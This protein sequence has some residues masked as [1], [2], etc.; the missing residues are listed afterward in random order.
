[1]TKLFTTKLAKLSAKIL[2]LSA[3]LL[4]FSSTKVLAYSEIYPSGFAGPMTGGQA[5]CLNDTPNQL[6]V[7]WGTTDCSSA[8]FIYQDYMNSA[9]YETNTLTNSGGTLVQSNSFYTQYFG[10][11]TDYYTPSTATPGVFYYYVTLSW[12]SYGYCSYSGPITTPVGYMDSIEV[13]GALISYSGSPYCT[14]NVGTDAPTLTG[15]SGGVYTYTGGTYS[16]TPAGLT[17]DAGTGAITPGTSTPGIYTV[18]YTVL[19][20]GPCPTE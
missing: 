6:S 19:A 1:M 15:Y 11:Q 16:A 14:S 3:F 7:T 20:N 9:W 2:A 18:D 12:S 17:I 13:Y 5:Y 8:D 4:L 10:N